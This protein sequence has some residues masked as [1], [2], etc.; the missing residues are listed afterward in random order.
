[1]GNEKKDI[2]NRADVELL[3]NTFYDRVKKDAT[4]GFFFTEIIPVD[5]PAHLPKMYAFWESIL[6]GTSGYKGEPMTVHTHIHQKH[7][8][9][10]EHFERW[11]SL[12]TSTIDELFSGNKAEE[13]KQRASSIA[14]IMEWKVTTETK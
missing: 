3:V 1:M 8:M 9:T 2:T 14:T 13:L 12:F 4:I 5:F 7:K 10:H 6:F 11:I